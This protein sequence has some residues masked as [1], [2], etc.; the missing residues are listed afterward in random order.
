ML[1]HGTGLMVRPSLT[2]LFAQP[3]LDQAIADMG[4]A[5]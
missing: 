4:D 5:R 3:R 2:R 1:L